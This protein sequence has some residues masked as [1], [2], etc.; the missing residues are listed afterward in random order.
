MSTGDN[1]DKIPFDEVLSLVGDRGEL[2][3][4]D[5]VLTPVHYLTV[6]VCKRERETHTVQC[7]IMSY[8]PH[9]SP[10]GEGGHTALNLILRMKKKKFQF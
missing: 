10:T 8:Q 1:N 6:R 9:E 7:H 3:G 2:W 5:E 4:E